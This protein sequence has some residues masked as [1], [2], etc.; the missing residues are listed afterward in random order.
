MSVKSGSGG[1]A[2]LRVVVHGADHLNLVGEI[3]LR[4]HIPHQGPPAGDFCDRVSQIHCLNV[5]VYYNLPHQRPV[6]GCRLTNLDLGCLC[7]AS[8]TEASNGQYV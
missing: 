5:S 7:E 8:G 1:L 6:V 2:I 4:E 3:F